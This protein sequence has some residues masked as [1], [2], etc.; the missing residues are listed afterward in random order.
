MNALIG[1][2]L[3]M[4]QLFDEESRTIPVTVVK[5]GP[6]RVVQVKTAETDGYDAIQISYRELDARKVNKPM[7]GHFAKA[8]VPP[9]RHLIEVRVPDASEYQVGQEI[10][11]ADVLE[12][13]QKADVAGL[14]KGKGFAGV[15]KRHNFA[16]QQASHGVHR[17]HRAPGAI[18][19]CATPARVFK[20]M[21]MAGRMGNEKTTVMNLDIVKVDAERGLAMLRGSVPGNKGS[22]VVVRKAVKAGG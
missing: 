8:N 12:V 17:V 7:A 4:T 16:G 3:G 18:G 21:P 11:V 10:N 6:C 5:L 15:M 20:G 9:S 13:G 22:V 14:S 1:E 19:A 2:K